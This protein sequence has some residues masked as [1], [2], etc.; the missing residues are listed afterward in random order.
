MGG[1]EGKSEA[2]SL[3]LVQFLVENAIHGVFV[4]HCFLLSANH[5]I[6]FLSSLRMTLFFGA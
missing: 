3:E 4:A 1:R 5:T 6:T 2:K